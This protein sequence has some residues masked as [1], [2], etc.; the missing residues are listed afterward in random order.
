MPHPATL[1]DHDAASPRDDLPRLLLRTEGAAALVAAL[2]AYRMT[3]GHWPLLAALALVPDLSIAGYFGGSKTGALL[4][5]LCHTYLMPAL[6]AGIGLVTQNNLCVHMALIWC[7]HIGLDRM[8]GFGL[9]YQSGFG[10]T[11]LGALSRPL[12]AH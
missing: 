4:Y 7:A 8:L 11:H 6:L 9:K 10:A 12:S 5:N 1:R 3:G 2:T